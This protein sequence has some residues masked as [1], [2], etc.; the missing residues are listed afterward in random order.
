MK[1]VMVI[2][3]SVLPVN[4]LEDMCQEPTLPPSLTASES[5]DRVCAQKEFWIGPS[6][7]FGGLHQNFSRVIHEGGCRTTEA[8]A[9]AGWPD[10]SRR[11]S[12]CN[13][14]LGG[15]WK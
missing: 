13:E 9:Q 3:P 11:C 7:R 2:D 10:G 8:V 4:V 6:T 12:M 5:A 15:S 14:A 1:G